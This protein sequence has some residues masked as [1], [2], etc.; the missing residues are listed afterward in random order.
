[1]EKELLEYIKHGIH[2]NGNPVDGYEVN[3]IPTG[4]FKINSLDDL[5]V[6]NFE[7]AAI[8]K[9]TINITDFTN[10]PYPVFKE[11]H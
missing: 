6:E 1:M 8:K 2:I 7:L 11:F 3:T 9:G 4:K 10:T 5:T